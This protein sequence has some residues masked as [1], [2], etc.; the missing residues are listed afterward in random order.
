MSESCECRVF[1]RIQTRNSFNERILLN[2][3]KRRESLQIL[4]LSSFSSSLLS[5]FHHHLEH[6]LLITPLNPYVSVQYFRVSILS[7]EKLR[8]TSSIKN[9][10]LLECFNCS[11]LSQLIRT[12]PFLLG[13]FSSKYT[14]T[15]ILLIYL[16]QHLL[17]LCCIKTL[18]I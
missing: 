11:S 16:I 17:L 18:I 13:S 10:Q 12:S 8:N 6:H 2:E 15:F 14:S 4:S 5:F 9:F 7:L 1:S 3:R